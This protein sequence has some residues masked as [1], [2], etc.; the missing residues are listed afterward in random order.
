MSI[1]ATNMT[2][3]SSQLTSAWEWRNTKITDDSTVISWENLNPDIHV[4]TTWHKPSTQAVNSK[5]RVAVLFDSTWGEAQGLSITDST[6]CVLISS[7]HVFSAECWALCRCCYNAESHNNNSVQI[8]APCDTVLRRF[9]LTVFMAANYT[10]S[11]HVLLVIKQVSISV[12][13]DWF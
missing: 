3:A 12:L 1:V 4:R 9:D 6:H 7:H 5:M 10:R 11:Q 8:P 13:S 2:V